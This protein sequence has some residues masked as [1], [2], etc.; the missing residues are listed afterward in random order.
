[1]KANMLHGQ[2][3]QLYIRPPEHNPYK[4]SRLILEEINEGT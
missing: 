3:L 2:H 4:I 1:M